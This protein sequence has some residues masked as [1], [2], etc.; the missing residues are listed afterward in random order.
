MTSK[1]VSNIKSYQRTCIIWH[2]HHQHIHKNTLS[3][4]DFETISQNTDQISMHGFDACFR[5][6]KGLLVYKL[7]SHYQSQQTLVVGPC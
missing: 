5:L 7:Y 6:Y 2:E 1:L 3:L 4:V